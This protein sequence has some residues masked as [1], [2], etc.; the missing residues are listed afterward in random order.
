MTE[1]GLKEVGK[2]ILD[3]TKSVYEASKELI[4]KGLKLEP[5]VIKNLRNPREFAQAVRSDMFGMRKQLGRSLD[6]AVTALSEDNSTKTIDLSEHFSWLKDAQT[7]KDA[8]GNLINPGLKGEVSRIIRQVKDPEQAKFLNSLL[9][10]PE[11][12]RTL[13][14]RQA[15]DMKRAISQSPTV[16]RALTQGRFAH[17]TAGDTEI[18]D[19]LDNIKATQAEQFPE[20]SQLRQPY[21]RYMSAYN[22]VKGKFREGSLLGKMRGSFGDEETQALIK[23][24]VPQDTYKQMQLFNV[25][26]RIIT[27]TKVAGGALSIEEILR[28]LFR[29]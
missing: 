8:E 23:E 21:A 20:L 3:E 16:Q 26:S 14:L 12:A 10:N 25:G 27:G 24:V 9:N 28:R 18:L 5:Q 22:R 6:S 17:I 4:K 15:E 2:S 29:R 11:E 7:V 1:G 19:L 13:T